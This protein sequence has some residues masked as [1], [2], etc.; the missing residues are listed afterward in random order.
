MIVI[1]D[2]GLK[3]APASI[4]GLPTPPLLWLILRV[5]A[6]GVGLGV[7]VGV[8]VGEVVGVGVGVGAVLV[9]VKVA[10]AVALPAV[11]VMV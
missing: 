1:I 2:E 3:P 8:G 9:T 5:V 10:V 11:T 6:D 4:T 7:G